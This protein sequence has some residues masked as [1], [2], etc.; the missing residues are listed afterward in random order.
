MRA[1]PVH[2]VAIPGA[3]LAKMAI[4]ALWC[5]PALPDHRLKI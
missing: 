1:I 2:F 4:G 5:S 3:A